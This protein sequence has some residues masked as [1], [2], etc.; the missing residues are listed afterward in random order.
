MNSDAV[1]RAGYAETLGGKKI[2][3]RKQVSN[4]EGGK[5][6]IDIDRLTEAE[7]IEL[8]NKVVA[9]LRFLAQMR[10]HA[11]MLQ[12]NIGERVSFQPQDQPLV[13]G[14]LTRYN[15]K[16]V[17]VITDSG[18]RW[19]IAPSLLRKAESEINPRGEEAN[20]IQLHKK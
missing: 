2:V 8:N 5:M 15:R 6:K 4:P 12:F 1:T 16:S 11:Q 18:E 10:A 20:V 14:M 9:R 13:T 17:T 3:W 7:L 19:N